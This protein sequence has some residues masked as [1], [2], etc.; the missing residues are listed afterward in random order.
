MK[1]KRTSLLKFVLAAILTLPSGAHAQPRSATLPAAS[2]QSLPAPGFTERFSDVTLRVDYTFSGDSAG[3]AVSLDRLSSSDGWFGRRVN[4]ERMPLRGN[5]EVV[6]TDAE[7]GERLYAWSFSSL[8]SEWLATDEARYTARSFEHTVLLPMPR[9]KAGVSLRLFD[10]HGSVCAEHS[11]ILDPS[12]ILIRRLRPS[13]VRW[14]YLHS[15]GDSRDCID[16]VIMAEGYAKRDMRRFRKDARAACDA[17]L[18]ASPFSLFR[19]RLNVIAVESV[20]EDSG[21]SEPL[22]GIWRGTAVGS[23]FSTFYSDRYLTSEN[24]HDIHDILSGIPCEHIIILANTDTYG[25]GG[26]YNSYT[27]TTAHHDN[28]RP[29]V[30]HEFGHS[31]GG[32]ADEYFYDFADVLDSSYDV[33]VEPWEP[34]ITTLVDFDAKWRNMLPDDCPIPTPGGH[35]K[36]SELDSSQE[37]IDRIGVYEGG[38]YLLHGIFR[39]SDNC[40]M[41]T[42]EA[43]GFCPVCRHALTELI[44]FY[45]GD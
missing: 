42:N 2:V 16:V 13:G 44:L 25:G 35:L 12:D 43:A 22:K 6:M 38:G 1:M 45:T 11:F 19:D 41:R 8:F 26:I 21:V 36:V 28:F 3:Q 10:K 27:L 20:S 31:F 17:L 32:L 23:H 24:V 34:N 18:A 29:V 9:A 5:G 15:G 30:V 4:L 40:R 37:A 14:G 7:T 39:P 33:S